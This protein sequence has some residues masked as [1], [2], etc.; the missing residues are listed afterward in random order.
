MQV[1][2]RESEADLVLTGA[3]NRVSASPV[4]FGRT[5][6]GSTFLVTVQVSLAVVEKDT[7]K[8]IFAHP[9]FVF[10]ERY[11]IN[12]EVENFF[13]ELNPALQRVADDLA[14][15][16]VATIREDF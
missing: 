15:S 9:A 11:V 8:A 5:A 3:V 6:L 16:I 14:S 13:S 2:N 7:G 12:A 10:Q 1:V 4:T